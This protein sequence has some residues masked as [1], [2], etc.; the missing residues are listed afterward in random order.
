MNQARSPALLSRQLADGHGLGFQRPQR[1]GDVEGLQHHGR[2]GV[3]P[4]RREVQAVGVPHPR[5]RKLPQG[6]KIGDHAVVACGDGPDVLVEDG[7]PAPVMAQQRCV[8]PVRTGEQHDGGA[9]GAEH[10]HCG[11]EGGRQPVRVAPVEDKVVSAGGERDQVRL[12]RDRGPELLVKDFTQ[13]EAVDGEVG[14]AEVR[15]A[16]AEFLGDAVGPTPHAART[17]RFRV[18]E[19]RRERIPHGDISAPQPRGSV[20][21]SGLPPALPRRGAPSAGPAGARIQETGGVH[22]PSNTPKILVSLGPK[23]PSGRRGIRRRRGA[24]VRGQRPEGEACESAHIG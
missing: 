4:D 2:D 3:V 16:L 5:V 19:A 21:W 20:P 17:Q 14:V 23:V 7:D 11:V 15:P 9:G 10:A 12:Q 1:V 22:T 13:D 24:G 6:P 18:P 8:A